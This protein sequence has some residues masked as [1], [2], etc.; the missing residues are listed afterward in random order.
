MDDA[1]TGLAGRFDDRADQLQHKILHCHPWEERFRRPDDYICPA[2]YL[3]Q[4]PGTKDTLVCWNCPVKPKIRHT[5]PYVEPTSALHTEMQ[6]PF[7]HHHRTW[8]TLDS[9][10]E[11]RRSGQE[12]H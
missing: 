6:C 2:V 8:V 9:R 4:L 12:S 1:H 11:V 3:M 10:I 7:C 5:M